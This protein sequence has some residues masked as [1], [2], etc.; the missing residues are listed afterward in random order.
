LLLD[1]NVRVPKNQFLAR[2]AAAR[3]QAPVLVGGSTYERFAP[4]Q[5]EYILRWCYGRMREAR[6]AIQRQRSA[7]A[8]FNLKNVLLKATVLQQI[9]LDE[10]L[11]GYGHEDTRFGWDLRAAAI[12]VLHLDNPVLHSF[13]EPAD[14]FLRKTYEGVR[15][16]AWLYTQEGIGT[17][18]KLLRAAVL[19]RRWGL[20]SAARAYFRLR[21]P[22][23]Q[24]NLLSVTPS[25]RQLDELK[26]YW[27][28]TELARLNKRR[29]KS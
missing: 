29:P 28:L 22:K 4:T 5:L 13:L 14:S 3:E 7:Y 9:P 18:A 21:E 11:V 27:L 23:M 20:S 25:L 24:R 12:P 6:P 15:N 26:L 16:L 19:L 17:E 8:H 1:N 10:R 2:Y